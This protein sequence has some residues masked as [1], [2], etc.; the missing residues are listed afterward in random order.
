[1]D[2]PP[3]P[4]CRCVDGENRDK[5]K[6]DEEKPIGGAKELNRIGVEGRI[7]SKC[8]H[9]K[10]TSLTHEAGNYAVE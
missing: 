1:M 6:S 4:L 10:V 9:R 7:N 5:T 8:S 3:V 2:S